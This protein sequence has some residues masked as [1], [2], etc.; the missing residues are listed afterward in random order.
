MFHTLYG[1][2]VDKVRPAKYKFNIGDQVRISKI[3]GKFEKS[4]LPNFQK[5]YLL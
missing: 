4:Y 2:V 3:K 5:K 1:S